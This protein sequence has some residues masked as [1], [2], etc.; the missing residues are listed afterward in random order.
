MDGRSNV[1]VLGRIT[2]PY[3]SGLPE[4]VAVWDVAF[5][6]ESGAALEDLS[7]HLVNFVNVYGT[8]EP[9]AFYLSDYV[10]RSSLAA[11]VDIY[12]IPAV[13]GPLGSPINTEQ[14]TVGPRAVGGAELPT[15]VAACTSFHAELSGIPEES[16]DTR[17]RA[18]R[19]GRVYVGPLNTFAISNVPPVML[20]G[21]FITD[22]IAATKGLA[23]GA[24]ADLWAMSVFS[25]TDWLLRPVIGGY[26]DNA[27]DIQRRR[28]VEATS[29]TTWVI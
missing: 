22:L 5:A 21:T 11:K 1:D 6:G 23:D 19:R 14:F 17:P 15:E 3:D 7:T 18:R 9:L 27:V 16:G 10:D 25:R 20:N 12:E 28:G 4:D 24:G 8:T 29:R 13:E 2:I 26:V